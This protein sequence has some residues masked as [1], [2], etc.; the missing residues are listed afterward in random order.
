MSEVA[1]T[2]APLSILLV[3]DSELDG[4]LVAERLERGG[5]SHRL[6]RVATRAAFVEALA[7]GDVDIV[8]S[9]YNV[10][11]FGGADALAIVRSA[12]PDVPFLFV[13][14]ALG[15]ELAVDL[16]KL[17]AT[18]YV[19]KDRLHR[20]V[21]SVTRAVAEAREKKERERAETALREAER[22]ARTLLGN[23]PGMAFRCVPAPPWVFDFASAGALELSGWAPEAFYAGGEITW[24]EIMHPGD[25]ERV[26]KEAEAAFSAKRQ[27]TV[28]YRIRTRTGEERWVWDRS[29]GIYGADGELVALEGFVTDVTEAKR[30]EQEAA[31]HAELEQQLIGV[32][33]HDLRSPLQV[34]NLASDA[35]L[36]RADL[37]P[38]VVEVVRRMQRAGRRSSRMIH[39]LLDFTQARLGGGI[40]IV[41]ATVE[42]RDVVKSV[43]EEIEATSPGREIVI[44]Q[45]EDVRGTWDFDRLAQ[46]VSNLIS[47]AISYGTL[48]TKV[49]VVARLDGD[50][51]VVEVHNEGPPIPPSLE[52]R[53]FRPMQ[54]GEVAG[55]Q[56]RSVGLGLYI[57]DHLVRRHG[58]TVSARSA[59]GRTTFA[60]RLPCA[61]PR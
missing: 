37:P 9:D 14:G 53:L 44:E 58:G 11:G 22:M 26:A 21:P 25:V 47:N 29:V 38:P 16:L 17:G 48:G 2:S 52:P 3:E 59:D 6:H 8:L 33:S 20:L 23:M 61:P 18:D 4:E 15:E 46:V 19:L 36:K 27:L 10:P 39:D 42:L 54:R 7:R 31:A 30:A 35:L 40:P 55:H 51:A 12:H 45:H 49:H 1:P 34:I 41:P 5:L 32:V 24:S 28:S 13:S 43:V 57:V 50:H 56:A 60:V